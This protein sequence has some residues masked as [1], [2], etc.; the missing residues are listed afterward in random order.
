MSTLSFL[1]HI[2]PSILYDICR[3]V[4]NEASKEARF[5]VK[6]FRAV[7]ERLRPTFNALVI[8]FSLRTFRRY[9][10]N[11]VKRRGTSNRA[12]VRMRP[13][14]RSLL[15]TAKKRRS[16]NERNMNSTLDRSP[17]NHRH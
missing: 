8:I 16:T 5:G 14:T 3:G 7:K 15:E 1:F 6:H 9:E 10:E 12:K 4:E 17:R 11:D 2:K 13:R